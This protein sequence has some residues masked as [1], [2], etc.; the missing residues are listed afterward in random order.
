MINKKGLTTIGIFILIFAI[1]IIVVFLGIYG[2]IFYNINTY[3]SSLNVNVGAVNLT[4]VNADTLGKISEGYLNSVDMIAYILIFSL[5]L[6]MVINAYFNRDKYPSIMLIVDIL[7]MIFYYIVAVYV[8]NTY[9]V[10][11]NST[12]FLSIYI[13]YMPKASRIVLHLP[14]IISIVGVIIMILSYSKLPKDKNELILED[15]Y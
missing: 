8:S 10:F 14:A 2:L 13:D 3:L 11:I 12:S 7:L 15:G 4:S 6:F 5:I 9:Y 1:L